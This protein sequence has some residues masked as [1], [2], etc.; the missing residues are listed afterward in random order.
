MKVPSRLRSKAANGLTVP[1]PTP[2][3]RMTTPIQS[4]RPQNRMRVSFSAAPLSSAKSVLRK[5]WERVS[6]DAREA[7]IPSL[8]R[9]AINISR[10]AAK[11]STA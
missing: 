3:P 7:M 4:G 11:I 6:K 10:L 1:V 9:S 2:A 5:A 8:T